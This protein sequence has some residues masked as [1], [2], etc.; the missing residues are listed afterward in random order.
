MPATDQKSRKKSGNTQL[1]LCREEDALKL[2]IAIS[3]TIWDNLPADVYDLGQDPDNLASRIAARVPEWLKYDK[4]QVILS[5]LQGFLKFNSV[6]HNSH[7]NLS[8]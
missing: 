5:E 2:P 6:Y 7:I 8:I 3:S 1:S 4:D